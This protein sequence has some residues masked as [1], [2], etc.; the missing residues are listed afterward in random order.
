[1]KILILKPSSLGDVIHALPVLR[2]LKRH[3]PKSQIYWWL[4]AG[5]YQLL[6]ED[7]D[8]TGI[9]QFHRRRWQS[10]LHWGELL[11]SIL[12][13][14]RHRFDLVID[15]QSLA[16][17]ATVAWLANGAMTIGLDDP[18]EGAA[19]F[20][21]IAV[22]RPSPVTHAVDWYLEVL[23][24]LEVPVHTDY[25]WLPERAEIA[26]L[27]RHKWAV[28]G[29]RWILLNPGA[30]W[31]NK[32]WPVEHFSELVK[33]LS[34][35]FAQS[36]FAIMGGREDRPLGRRIAEAA[37]DRCLD[38]T[39][40]TS[41]QEMVQWIRIADLII[42]NDTGPMHVA[43]AV[44]TPVVALFGPTD[45][46]RTGPYGQVDRVLSHR[47]PCAPCLKDVCRFER[48]MECLRA[49]TPRIVFN[50]AVS[51]IQR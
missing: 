28:D 1:M 16:R 49:V 19:A 45:P 31:N 12:E 40:Q 6:E 51:R 37:P 14:R 10:V 38:L 21:D 5:L 30:R 46:R 24:N 50:E 17:S 13:L 27:V 33:L 39:G 25:E 47:L 26:T 41:L 7:R 15:L 43:V 4:D 34:E 36:R 22:P 35:E 3:F 8:L 48:P 2:L 42:T 18:R 23:R 44:D 20:Y 9:V 32:R 29:N 11:Q